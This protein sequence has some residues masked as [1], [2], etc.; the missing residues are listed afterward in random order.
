MVRFLSQKIT[1]V[2]PLLRID[3]NGSK[4]T[5]HFINGEGESSWASLG[6]STFDCWGDKNLGLGGCGDNGLGGLAGVFGDSILLD[7][8]LKKVLDLDLW[9]VKG[10][11]DRNILSKNVV[12]SFCGVMCC[13]GGGGTSEVRN[14][15]V[16]K[17]LG[18]ESVTSGGETITQS[19]ET[20]AI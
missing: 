5:G 3:W 19:H 7:L 4:H 8:D 15:G 18:G 12:G 17:I 9:G 6:L 14:L 13:W 20:L 2:I 1:T 16:G 11:V 10:L